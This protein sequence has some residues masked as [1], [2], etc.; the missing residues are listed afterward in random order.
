[1]EALYPEDTESEES[2]EGTAAHWY[3]TE[4]AA[5]RDP[6]PVA[7]NGYPINDE[8]RQAARGCLHRLAEI[9]AEA[10]P[11]L[12]LRIEERVSAVATVHPDNWGTPDFYLI[13][14]PR[15]YLYV[16]DYK[17]GHRYVDH[18]NNWQ[19][20][21]YEACILESEGV[22][23][24]EWKNWTFVTTIAQPRN[25]SHKGTIRTSVMRGEVFCARVAELRAAAHEAS[26][27]QAP[28]RTG[29]HCR[30][31]RA[32][33]P[34]PANQQA[35]FNSI[36]VSRRSMPLDMSAV[37]VGIEL[38]MI[39]QAIERLKARQTGLEATAEGMLRTGTRVPWWKLG[40]VQSRKKWKLPADTVIT[41]GRMMGVELAKPLEAITP[42]QA[43]DAGID[44][45]IIEQLAERPS[46]AVRL[47]PADEDDAD[48]V[49]GPAPV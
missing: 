37:T 9:R 19:C 23:Q 14:F 6:G 40:N 1:M 36:D 39:A 33:T 43:E 30:D 4:T 10:T 16:I 38:R 13:D 8:M 46:G 47:E 2:R 24:G 31:C 34:C 12:A 42:N 32:M 44:P 7:P 5:G 41:M 22:P 18:R 45:T 15:Q 11:G 35:G 48:R 3:L 29:D 20:I 26:D 27:P 17:Y 49:F 21:D 28:C 25:F